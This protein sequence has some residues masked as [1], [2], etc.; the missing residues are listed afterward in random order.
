M[1]LTLKRPDLL[2]QAA[3]VGGAWVEAKGA[4]IA[5]TNPATGE[6]LGHVPNLGQAETQSAIEAAA[7]AQKAWAS[8]TAK[9]RA[10]VLK[11]V[12]SD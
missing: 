10:D 7:A 8:R 2:R 11:G 1:T 9:A 12:G 3:R 6:V 5:V 4:G